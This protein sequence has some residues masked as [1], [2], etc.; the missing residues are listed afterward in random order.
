MTSQTYT[1]QQDNDKL[2]ITVPDSPSTKAQP[3]LRFRQT[4][5]GQKIKTHPLASRLTQ[6]HARSSVQE[7]I[8][9]FSS[10]SSHTPNPA[11]GNRKLLNFLIPPDWPRTLAEYVDPTRDE[12]V[13]GVHVLSFTD[14]TILVV[15]FSHVLM[16]GGGLEAL[17][18][19]WSSMTSASSTVG[20]KSSVVVPDLALHDPLD[21]IR[22]Q[23]SC[24]ASSPPEKFIL[25]DRAIDFASLMPEDSSEPTLADPD[26]DTSRPGSRW[27]TIAFSPQALRRI[28]AE[29]VS[30]L[31][32]DSGVDYISEDDAVTAWL[33]RTCAGAYRSSAARPLNV[34][35]LYDMRGRLP[36]VFPPS[37][38]VY[39]QNAYQLAWTLFD[40]AGP[41]SGITTYADANGGERKA[42]TLG[43]VA[44]ALRSSIT[45]QTTPGQIVAAMA[46]RGQDGSTPIYGSPAGRF[47]TLNSW[48]KMDLYSKADFSGAVVARGVEDGD[49]DAESGDDD[50]GMDDEVDKKKGLPAFIDFD[51][52]LGGAPPGPNVISSGKCRETGVR[53][54]MAYLVQDMW[55]RLEAELEKLG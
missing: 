54:A 29:A 4:I 11:R 17:M 30:S 13:L 15:G 5:L 38:T 23:L 14:A 51:F 7:A 16:D 35:R 25:A 49:S 36:T 32:S 6:H 18:A 21:V 1:R 48:V 39:V 42:M 43:A 26:W 24:S 8:A 44:A 47:M 52:A 50:Y 3:A 33:V 27:R 12:P 45:T 28:K 41:V 31:P 22:K 2:S 53:Y 46:A 10:S 9:G 40:A 19:G 55:P 34:M 37:G 20:Q